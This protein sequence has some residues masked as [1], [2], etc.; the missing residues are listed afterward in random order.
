MSKTSTIP[1]T[2]TGRVSRARITSL[3]CKFLSKF[4]PGPFPRALQRGKTCFS[5]NTVKSARKGEKIEPQ[6]SLITATAFTSSFDSDF[7]VNFFGSCIVFCNYRCYFFVASDF[8]LPHP[9][10]NIT[11]SFHFCEQ[12]FV[13]LCPNRLA[14]VDNN[15]L[16]SNDAICTSVIG[17][18]L[19]IFR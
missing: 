6:T 5:K 3:K 15:T 2:E 14:I 13:L 8:L 1:K 4:L 18:H 10:Q 9:M 16:F 11:A 12:V 19:K 7:L 17:S